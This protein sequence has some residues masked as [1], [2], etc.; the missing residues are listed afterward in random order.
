MLYYFLCFI[1]ELWTYYSR[2][3]QKFLSNTV[4][5][6]CK[7]NGD[8]VN[9][10]YL[11]WSKFLTWWFWHRA[12]LW[13][14]S[15][16]PPWRHSWGG[17]LSSH[18]S[19]AVLRGEDLFQHLFQAAMGTILLGREIQMFVCW[20]LKRTIVMWKENFCREHRG[21]AEAISSKFPARRKSLRGSLA[22]WAPRR[23]CWR[24]RRTQSRWRGPRCPAGTS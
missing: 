12:W 11:V 2:G 1:N 13:A 24:R 6:A 23:W 5:E 4:A 15:L 21:K 20:V 9:K 8:N 22:P 14:K 16:F 10:G 19:L 17:S 3:T 7:K 18:V